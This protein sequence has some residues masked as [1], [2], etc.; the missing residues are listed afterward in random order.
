MQGQ[1]ATQRKKIVDCVEVIL[2]QFPK[3]TG[4]SNRPKDFH[5]LLHLC[6]MYLKPTHKFVEINQPQLK[7]SFFNHLVHLGQ[8]YFNLGPEK[9]E[10]EQQQLLTHSINCF[11]DKQL[12]NYCRQAVQY[13]ETGVQLKTREYSFND[14]HSLLDITFSRSSRSPTFCY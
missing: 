5:H 1:G 14:R 6:H 7:I 8:R 9:E 3:G 11:Q 10:N 4:E 13:H 2:R 12:P